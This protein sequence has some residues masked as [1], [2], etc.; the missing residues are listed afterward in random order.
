MSEEKIVEEQKIRER[1]LDR[2]L[3]GYEGEAVTCTDFVKMAGVY[4][5]YILTGS[6][7]P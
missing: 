3:S 2:V 4:S 1:C 7:S 6:T 5:D